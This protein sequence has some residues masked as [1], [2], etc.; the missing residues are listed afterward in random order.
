MM[1]ITIS[2]ITYPFDIKNT[3]H[4]LNKHGQTLNTIGNFRTNRFA[5]NT[6][7]LLK[8]GELR[9][10]HAIQPD[11][12]AQSPSTQSRAFPV[13]FHKTDIVLPG[14]YAYNFQ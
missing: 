9:N 11:F 12:P 1:H 4:F 10:F 5:I 6:A 14:I 13:I 8:I 2:D 3:V 7:A